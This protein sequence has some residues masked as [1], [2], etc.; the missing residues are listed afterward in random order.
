MG[1]GKDI[2]QV[3]AREL[4]DGYDIFA[5]PGSR[6]LVSKR[7]VGVGLTCGVVVHWV[8]SLTIKLIIPW[9]IA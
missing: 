1:H 2:F 4:L 8:I 9:I 5:I 7:Q 3:R 6:T